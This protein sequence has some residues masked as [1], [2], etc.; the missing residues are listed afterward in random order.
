MACK[1]FKDGVVSWCSP[2]ELQDKLKGGYSVTDITP[3]EI[4]NNKALVKAKA[5]A[6]KEKAESVA[7]DSKLEEVQ[8]KVTKAKS[9]RRG[10]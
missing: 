6:K 4:K 3:E 1:L 9:K 7:A 2:L 5:S 8:Q 10:K